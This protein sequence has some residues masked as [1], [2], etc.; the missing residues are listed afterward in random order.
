MSEPNAIESRPKL[1]TRDFIAVCFSSFFLFMTFYIL[2]V[3]L[4]IFVTDT[5]HGT[6]GEIGPVMTVFVVAGLIFRPL[7]GKWLDEINRRTIV[8]V[9]LGLFFACSGLYML[10]DSYAWL[11]A[12]RL[13]HGISFGMGATAIGAIAMDLV[14]AA[15]KGE[16]VG[17]YS[18]FMSLAMVGGPAIGLMITESGSNALLF[19]T[20]F[21]LALCGLACGMSIRIP[22]RLPRKPGPA[23][24]GWRQFIEPAAVPIGLT[25]AVLAFSYGA[26]T[27][28]L[29]VYAKSLDL[30]A[31]ASVFFMVFALMIVLSRP[32]TGKMYDRSG[33]HLLVYPGI[34]LFTFGM[35]GLGGAHSLQ[36]FLAMGGVLGLGYGALF[37]SFQTIAI[38][39]AQPHRSGLATGTFFLLFDAGYGLGSSVLGMVSAHTGYHAM[40]IIGGIVVA[41]SGVMYYVLHH[42]R[43]ASRASAITTAPHA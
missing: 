15:R 12:L 29:S 9:A 2:A 23:P 38:Q 32:F 33:P 5:L 4:P 17:Y 36:M 19:G 6:Q 24:K 3:T 13:I 10:V 25:G 28:F 35:M 1:W 34:V 40:Y 21:A 8:I 43:S 37:P 18:L 30:S 14:P 31:Y 16:G 41:C 11:L 20:C 42:R 22:A 26:I 27:T 39:S 7:A